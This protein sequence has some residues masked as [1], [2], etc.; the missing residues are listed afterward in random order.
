MSK[1]TKCTPG[2]STPT[3]TSVTCST[4]TSTSSS[5]TARQ[6]CG[7]SSTSESRRRLSEPEV[8]Q[9]QD[10]HRELSDRRQQLL[11]RRLPGGVIHVGQGPDR[12]DVDV[13]VEHHCG[14]G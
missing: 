6:R 12:A 8:D 3:P 14:E 11:G 5:R 9:P 1:V 2:P 7:R 13:A 4:S 10:W